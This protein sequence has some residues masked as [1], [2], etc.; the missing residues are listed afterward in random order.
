MATVKTQLLEQFDVDLEKSGSVYTT[1]WTSSAGGGYTEAVIMRGWLVGI[2][3]IPGS[4]GSQPS[5]N[6][7]VTLIDSNSLDALATPAGITNASGTSKASIGLDLSNSVTEHY[8]ETNKQQVLRYLN[9][10]YTVT[11]ANAG[12][13]KSGTI[14]WTI[15]NR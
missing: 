14:V 9:G 12:N 5:S 2:D 6:Y 15:K 3:F 13:T 1:S 4:G 7:D 8:P 11:V 10:S